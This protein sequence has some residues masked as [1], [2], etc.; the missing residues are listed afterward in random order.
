[1]AITKV[2]SDVLDVGGIVVTESGTQTL[3]NKTFTSPAIGG[4][5]TGVGVLTSATAQASTSGTS[6]D[7]T[8]IPSWAKRITVMF[9]GVSTNTNTELL[10]Q[11]GSGSFETSG[12]LSGAGNR[13]G[14]TT[15]TAG[16]VVTRGFGASENASGYISLVTLGSN[17]W[18]SSGVLCPTASGTFFG[19]GGNKT[20]SGVVDRLRITTVSGTATFDAGSINILFE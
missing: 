8:G 19:S 15:S 6:I 5:P 3:T 4:T 17:V 9:S 13:G 1:M 14:D 20:T 12:Y 11:I 2:V 18:A 16:F 10:L 7:F